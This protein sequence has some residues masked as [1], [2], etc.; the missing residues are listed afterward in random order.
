MAIVYTGRVISVEVDR[1]RFPNGTE[2]EVTIVRHPAAV[3]VLPLE[4]DGR[5]VLIKQFR[6]AI[7]RE[8]WEVP[9]G[10]LD[11]GE[12]P[13]H[14]AIRE[15]E[16]ETGRVPQQVERLG[17]WYPAPGYCDE[18]LI[19]FRGTGLREP[20]PGSRRPPD[21]DEYITA[22]PFAVAEALAMV[23]RGEIVDLKTAYGL[24]LLAAQP[25]HA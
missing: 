3:V 11:E 4:A 9:A 13:E 8:L 12:S 18:L 2:H 7:D 17:A 25:P 10:S 19:F 1:K 14:A 24:T 15:C 21:E 23:A 5:V 22:Q 16:E 20:A 6:P